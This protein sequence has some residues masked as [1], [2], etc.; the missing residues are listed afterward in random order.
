MPNP[1]PDTITRDDI[2]AAITA[3]DSGAAEGP[4]GIV[5]DTLAGP[6]FGQPAPMTSASLTA[7]LR[8]RSRVSLKGARASPPTPKARP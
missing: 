2:I 7:G 8:G 3:F 1:L 4:R 6:F 5:S